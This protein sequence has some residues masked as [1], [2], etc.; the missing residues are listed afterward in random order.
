MDYKLYTDHPHIVLLYIFH[1]YLHIHLS[2]S[3]YLN[4]WADKYFCYVSYSNRP[5]V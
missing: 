3:S 2:H 1:S 5:L 4:S